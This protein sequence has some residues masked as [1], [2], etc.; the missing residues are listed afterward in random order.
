[1]QVRANKNGNTSSNE[2]L[3][4]IIWNCENEKM[5]IITKII[6]I[7]AILTIIAALA[8][9]I[10]VFNTPNSSKIVATPTDQSEGDDNRGSLPLGVEIA[11][12]A[13]WENDTEEYVFLPNG[14]YRYNSQVWNGTFYDEYVVEKKGYY[15]V[16]DGQLML[17]ETNISVM[18]TK[19]DGHSHQRNVD[20]SLNYNYSFSGNDTTLTLSEWG[21]ISAQIYSQQLKIV[22]TLGEIE[23]YDGQKVIVTGNLTDITNDTMAS[24][25]LDNGY[26]EIQVSFENYTDGNLSDFKDKYV[27]VTGIIYKP[28]VDATLY[29][30]LMRDVESIIISEA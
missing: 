14:A 25:I 10:F 28:D 11:F 3:K 15:A 13:L 5:R 26:I 6:S 16:M 30:P 2:K 27:E 19:F 18:L 24:L 4:C 21:N 9:G 12:N 8:W 17:N 23:E 7:M 22:Q 29:K 1:M 20:I